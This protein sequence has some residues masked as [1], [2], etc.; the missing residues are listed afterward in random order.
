MR[1]QKKR[2]GARRARGT[3]RGRD[4]SG[5]TLCVNLI[6]R[7]YAFFFKLIVDAVEAAISAFDFRR[8]ADTG[9]LGC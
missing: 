3:E 4:A 5:Y 8:N 6:E 7:G 2:T 1:K 9:M